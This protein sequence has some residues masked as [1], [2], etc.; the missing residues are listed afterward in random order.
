MEKK[1]ILGLVTAGLGVGLLAAACGGDGETDPAAT[2][3]EG[4]SLTCAIPEIA[5]VGPVHAFRGEEPVPTGFDPIN[6]AACTFTE[7]IASVTV[8]L[9]RQGQTVLEHTMGLEPL[10][11]EV[12]FPLRGELVPVVPKD[13][14]TGRYDR[15]MTATSTNGETVEVK[16]DY[17]DVADVIW[18]FD[19]ARSPEGAAREALAEQLGVAPG[20]P[21]MITFEPMEWADTSLGCPEPGKFYAQ[22]ITP[23]FRLVLGHTVGTQV[24]FHEYHTNEDGSMVV[25]CGLV[26]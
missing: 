11:T 22:V 9:L 18:I 21:S 2:P 23:G 20:A 8:Q 3:A 24:E 19:S 17:F 15:L 7:P 13:L 10:S 26:G 1:R 14:G 16:L 4:L 25:S 12:R 5:S 6:L